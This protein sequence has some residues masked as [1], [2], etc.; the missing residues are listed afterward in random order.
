MRDLVDRVA[1]VTGGGS[2]M[3]RAFAQRFA[4]E[5]MRVV[6]ADINEDA[7]SSAVSEIR[8]SGP[9]VLGVVTDVS[10]VKAVQELADR[11]LDRF[12]GVHLVVNNAGV[13]GYLDGPIWEATQKDWAWTLGVNLMG[14]INGI[15]TFVPILL[16]ENEGHVVNTASMTSVVRGR[17]MYAVTKQAVLALTETLHEHL[18]AAG[19]A[20]G[21]TALLP[22]TI[23]T[24]LFWGSRNRPAALR[25]DGVP[26]VSEE[27]SRLRED[28]HGRLSRGMS[29]TE[30]ADILIK[31]IR[32]EQFYVLTDHEWD[33]AIRA[34]T[35]DILARKNPEE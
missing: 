17:N 10:D 14:V 19:S 30:V 5:G 22:G 16:R 9:E 29:P 33:D 25:N 31:A 20:V 21:V 13:E 34:R 35:N 2:G 23:A 6:L 3:G 1:V 4:E 27:G 7:L 11:T 26:L 15:R 24:N 32:D 8:E 18:R 12:D 28:F